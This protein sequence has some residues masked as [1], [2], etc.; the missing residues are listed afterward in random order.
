MRTACVVLGLG[1]IASVA[2]T[3]RGGQLPPDSSSTQGARAPDLAAAARSLASEHDDEPERGEGPEGLSGVDSQSTRLERTK[4]IAALR[5][6]GP[7]GLSAALAELDR[8]SDV[9]LRRR[10]EA[11]VDR[12]AAQRDASASR[13]YWY[14]D[15]GEAERVARASGRPILALRLLGRLDEELSCANSRFFRTALYPDPRVNAVLRDRFVL[16]WSSERPAP[17]ATIDFGDGRKMV[18]TVT[19]NSLHYVLDAQGRP[20]DAIPGL[21]TPVAFVRAL[22]AADALAHELAGLDDGARAVRLR[23]AETRELGRL[24]AAWSVE[25]GSALR[26]SPRPPT[27]AVPAAVAM[28]IAI[29]KAFVERPLVGK[30]PGQP[31]PPADS[32]DWGA[33][34][35]HHLDESRLDP[36]AIAVLRSK[37]PM[38]W[39]S[40][41]PTEL[42]DAGFAQLVSSFERTMAQDALRNELVL[43]AQIR[44]WLQ[45]QPTMTLDEL[46][47]RVYREIFLTPA[48]DPWLGL[49]PPGAFTGI[50][51]DG[52][53]R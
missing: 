52:L 53:V 36:R 29:S 12:V 24:A 41:T 32:V 15:L 46:N 35:A 3:P 6:A 31:T 9:A 48:T 27:N 7:E 42:D 47:A 40:G 4:A 33:V 2:C 18:R 20:V 1:L 44:A 39:S 11:G 10:V 51:D 14:T 43:H 34:A 28:P 8:T 19:G 30:L 13:L 23:E 22:E 49:A 16:Y 38:N 25:T 37:H 17:V 21:Y 45:A 50:D 26:P 5:A